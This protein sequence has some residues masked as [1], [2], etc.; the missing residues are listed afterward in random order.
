V[1]E[2]SPSQGLIFFSIDDWLIRDGLLVQQ[3]KILESKIQRSPS[4]VAK[5][6][7]ADTSSSTLAPTAITASTSA[8]TL[9]PSTLTNS[10]FPS[11]YSSSGPQIFLRIRIQDT[12]DAAHLYTTISVYVI[13]Q[14]PPPRPIVNMFFFF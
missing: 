13:R 12:A 3:N 1:L 14:F 4:R 11:S 5:T 9:L 10:V 7:K 8:S 6:K 2:A